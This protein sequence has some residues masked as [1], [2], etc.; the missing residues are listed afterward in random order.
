MPKTILISSIVIFATS[1]FAGSGFIS[2]DTGGS[3]GTKSRLS[4]ESENGPDFNLSFEPLE[5]SQIGKATGF[6]QKPDLVYYR[7]QA[8]SEII[9]SLR[10]G[11]LGDSQ[12]IKIRPEEIAGEN[13][14]DLLKALE[15]SSRTKKWEPIL[16]IDSKSQIRI[17]LPHGRGGPR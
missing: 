11:F 6:R 17:D 5:K 3:S 13:S 10:L 7:G 16:G 2:N 8:H 14:E 9:F 1:A 4:A 15:K 12:L